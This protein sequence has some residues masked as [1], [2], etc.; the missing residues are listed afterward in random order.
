[1]T[2]PERHDHARWMRLALQESRN[3]LRAIG[4]GAYDFLCKPIQM[5]DL[6]AVV[7]DLGIPSQRIKIEE[8]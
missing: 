5:E 2:D 8:W 1:M 4:Q 7:A 6:K 3:A